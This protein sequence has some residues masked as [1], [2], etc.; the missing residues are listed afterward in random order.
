MRIQALRAAN[1]AAVKPF[2]V[3]SANDE[4]TVWLYDF[5]GFDA[6]TG[7]GVSAEAF[8][9]ELAGITTPVIRLRINSPGGSVFDGRAMY[10]ALKAHPSKVIASIE[11]VA[12]SAA[13]SVAMAADEVQMV[14]GSMFMIHN[15]WTIAMGNAND[16]IETAAL[17]EK[18]DGNLVADYTAKTG[19]SADQVS[20]WMAAETW[21]T[22]SEAV[23]AGFADKVVDG[24]Q[25]DASYDLSAYGDHAP[26]MSVHVEVTASADVEMTLEDLADDKRQQIKQELEQE[27]AS[28]WQDAQRR[29]QLVERTSA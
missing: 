26:K 14:K 5:I 24:P 16:L 13:T 7:T 3:Q 29:L 25:V 21:F 20:A 27:F 12:A 17:L 6:W 18:I 28:A 8:A 19:K 9:K 22:A 4:T 1:K 15:A 11:G 23:D 2:A 10:A